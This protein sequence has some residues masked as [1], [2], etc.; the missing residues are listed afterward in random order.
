MDFDRAFS[1][2]NGSHGTIAALDGLTVSAAC[3]AYG[4]RFTAAYAGGPVMRI[5]GILGFGPSGTTAQVVAST[6]TIYFSNVS[7]TSA[8]VGTLWFTDLST[9][10]TVGLE[11]TATQ[12][13]TDCAYAGQLIP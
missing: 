4:P 12:S 11:I 9:H 7:P 5:G 13:G 8:I 3:D 1:T 2:V 10:R 6:S